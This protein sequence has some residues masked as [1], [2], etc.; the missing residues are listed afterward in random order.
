MYKVF[1]CLLLSFILFLPVVWAREI[2]SRIEIEG[3]NIVSDATIVSKLK[4]RAGQPFR[5]NVINEDVKNLYATGFFD[6]VEVSKEKVANEIIVVFT[7]KEKPVLKK[8][9]FEGYRSIHRRKLLDAVDI[10]EGSFVDEYKLK[11]VSRKIKDL[12]QQKGFSQAQIDYELKID[13]RR[14]EAEVKFVIDERRVIKVRG[15]IVQGNITFSDEKIIRLMKTKKAW[16]LNRGLFK[17]DVLRDDV[18]RIRD[19]Y[20]RQGFSDVEVKTDTRRRPEGVYVTIL[21]DEGQRYYAGEIT[22]EGNKEVPLSEIEAV[23]KMRPGLVFSENAVYEDYSRIREIYVN[24]GY[25]FSRVEPFSYFNTKTKR[26]DLTYRVSENQIAYVERIDVKGNVKTRD[27]VIRREL[28]AYPG[29]R[30]NGEKIHKSK[31]RLENLGFFEEI[32]FGTEAGTTPEQIDLIVD[33]K[34]AKTGYLSFGGGYSSVDEFVGFVELRQRNFDYRNWST[35]T[36]AGQ[37]LNLQASFGTLTDRYQLSFTNPWIFDR[38]I[39]FGFDGYKRTHAR[40]GDVG[41]AFEEDIRGGAIRLGTAF[42]D[43]FSAGLGFRFE[44]VEISDVDQNATQALKDEAG[45]NDLIGPEVNLRFD[46]RDNVFV[47]STGIYVI[48]SVEFKGDPFG[49]DKDFVKESARVSKYFPLMH[50]SVLEFRVRVGYADPFSGTNEIPIYERFFAGGSSTIR[51]YHERK[52]GP[53]DPAT[54]DPLGG[55]AM[56]VGNVEY[57]YPLVENFLKMATFFDTGNVWEKNND[58]MSGDLKS[59]V[60]IGLRVKTPIG[61]VSVD[62]GWPLD[63]EPGEEEKEGRFHFNISRGF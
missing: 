38:P 6:T 60:G 28:R 59:S 37:D 2:V 7:V 54:E 19:F 47:P 14:N 50:D 22:I 44:Q 18:K 41:Y 23:L 12:Y 10:K 24:K 16:L 42:N 8:L 51:G 1:I 55:E 46:T 52:V 3:N 57:T 53:I 43:N 29:E 26:V 36:G 15:V 30:F 33:V 32:R 5:E 45:T 11:E 61:P 34:E 49:G 20:L 63:L 40:E 17:E 9:S 62:Y 27:N 31:E 21:I 25:I 56:F 39:S 48:N 58:F 13:E 35:F 4:V